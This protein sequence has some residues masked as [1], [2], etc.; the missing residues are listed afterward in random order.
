MMNFLG[1][2]FQV[3]LGDYYAAYIAMKE[4]KKDRTAYLSR[5]QD[6]LVKQALFAIRFYKTVYGFFTL[7]QVVLSAENASFSSFSIASAKIYS[8]P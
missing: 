2:V 4:R 1:T 6:S 3:E 7:A 8:V 5:L